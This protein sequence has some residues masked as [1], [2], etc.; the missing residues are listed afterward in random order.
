MDA[1]ELAEVCLTCALVGQGW[2]PANAARRAALLAPSVIEAL[3]AAHAEQAA[4]AAH[5]AE[6]AR[7]AEHAAAVAAATRQ[8]DGRLRVQIGLTVPN[9]ATPREKEAA[10]R[11]ALEASTRAHEALARAGRLPDITRAISSGAVRWAPEPPGQE[12]F[13]LAT[14]VV[15]R[16][17]GDCDDL[18]PWWAAQLRAT[19]RDPGARAIVRR[20]GER[21]WHAVVQR[22]D[23]SID[24]PSLAAGMRGRGGVRAM[25]GPTDRAVMVERV[26]GGE[27]LA[28][29]Q[30][31][32]EGGAI[33]GIATHADPWRAVGRAH[34]PHRLVDG[35]GFLPA[36]AAAVPL[37]SAAA[38]LASG[39]VS[40]FTG[41]GG[42]GAPP[43][44][45][46]GGPHVVHPGGGGGYGYGPVIVRF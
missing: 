13:D 43:A 9:D 26:S 10:F 15:G 1:R 40:K 22:S 5:A 4:A 30:G 8:D 18:A 11:A 25:R 38:P 2:A 27:Y 23:G 35:I 32:C 39:I 14:E 34:V 12:R 3:W 20:T 16:G 33:V 46:G 37:A 29:V 7:H 21:R 36:L 45:P 41:G 19:G 28:A 44:P 31:P 6:L 24:D 17:W 42:G